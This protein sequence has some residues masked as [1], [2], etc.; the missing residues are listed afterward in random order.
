M[1]RFRFW[2]EWR[3]AE[4]NP[5]PEPQHGCETESSKIQ[6]PLLFDRENR[7]IVVYDAYGNPYMKEKAPFGFR[8]SAT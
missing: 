8:R 7:P 3:K 2:T 1:R 4:G 6:S 5:A